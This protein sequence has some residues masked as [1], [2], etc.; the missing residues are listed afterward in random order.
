M[1]T[2]SRRFEGGPVQVFK[3]KVGKKP[4][5]RLPRDQYR[6]LDGQPD[7]AIDA[8][9]RDYETKFE[10][11]N[12]TPDHLLIGTLKTYVEDFLKYLEVMGLETNTIDYHRLCLQS[13]AVPFFLDREVPLRDVGQWPGVSVKMLEYL[14]G[15]Q[16]KPRMIHRVN[17]S[18]MK[19]W[20]WMRDEGLVNLDL[21]L[22]N[23]ANKPTKTPLKYTLSPA[24]AL[25]QMKDLPPQLRM[26]ALCGYFF[27]LRPQETFALTKADFRAG[28][29]VL[30]LECSKTLARVKL[31]ARFVVKLK[32]Q[33]DAKDNV[34][35]LKTAHSAA[36]VGCFNEEAAKLIVKTVTELGDDTWF[37]HGYR[38]YS[39]QWAET[40][41]TQKGLTF[42]F[43]DLRRAS[44]YW[45]GHNTELTAIELM[46]H[47]RHVKLETTM[48]YLR[49][50]DE[51]VESPLLLDLEA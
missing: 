20:N 48:L 30:A 29:S 19:F 46:K 11:K 27:S 5:A 40:W 14:T 12:V 50:P 16:V 51:I 13:Y 8:W 4:A 26:F 37:P 23:P 36:W 6:H 25:K 7:W 33:R 45:L 44:L 31:Y 18:L 38:Y 32:E 42:T 39:L 10:G 9:V 47:A 35:D 43:K 17:Q 21:R 1:A 49:R 15:R 34:K 2:W 22:R 41:P 28:S 24:D 3:K